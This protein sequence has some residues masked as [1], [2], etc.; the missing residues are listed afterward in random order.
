MPYFTF[1]SDAFTLNIEQIAS[2]NF[3]N[4]TAQAYMLPGY[5][6]GAI[7]GD[8]VVRLRTVLEDNGF[9]LFG[10]Y[11]LNLKL[12]S[13]VTWN[14]A[15]TSAALYVLPGF[16]SEVSGADYS[17]LSAALRRPEPV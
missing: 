15:D 3:T 10:D 7:T 14:D 6:T 4:G 8:D 5:Q 13:S 11:A 16:N 2:V 9:F 17:R 12:V 1:G